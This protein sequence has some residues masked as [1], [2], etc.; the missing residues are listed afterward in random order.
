RIQE[1]IAAKSIMVTGAAGSIGS[2]LCRQAASFVPSKLVLFDQAESEL[3]KMDQ[4]LRQKYPG[5]DIV[6]VVGDIRDYRTIDDVVRTHAIE[7]IYHAAAYKH[8]PMME[9]HINEAVRN[10]ILGTWN[11]VRVAQRHRVSNFLMI[12]SDKPV[13]PTTV[14]S[15][16]QTI[17]EL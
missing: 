15:V 13:N 2:E 16:T 7:S 4:E 6:A 17:A 5:I 9:A 1:S 8:V 14:M 3:F 11:V 12:S 10:N